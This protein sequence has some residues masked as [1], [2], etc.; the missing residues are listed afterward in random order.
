MTGNIKKARLR[1]L[2][3]LESQSEFHSF[4]FQIVP[5]AKP[6]GVQTVVNILSTTMVVGVLGDG[7]NEPPSGPGYAVDGRALAASVEQTEDRFKGSRIAHL[8]D[9]LG[10]LRCIRLFKRFWL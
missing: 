2:L 9:D 6:C 5:R 8:R 4:G 3:C 7:I 1:G 10:L